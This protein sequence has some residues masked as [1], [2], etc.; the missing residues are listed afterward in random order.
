MIYGYA[1]VST[2]NQKLDSQ[3]ESLE[4]YAENNGFVFDEII[5]EKCKGKKKLSER[6]GFKKLLEKFIQED[7]LIVTELDRLGRYSEIHYDI[8]ELQKLIN[9]TIVDD[10]K[11]IDES[12]KNIL[13]QSIIAIEEGKNI[14][15][16]VKRG[17]ESAKKRGVKLGRPKNK[18]KVPREFIEKYYFYKAGE[19]GDISVKKFCKIC[20]IGR[21][22]YYKYEK[23]LGKLEKDVIEFNCKRKIRE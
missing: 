11:D 18:E 1:R 4:L 10:G 7:I 19:Y 20:D 9:I 15:K 8:L 16:R 21:S 12:I 17:L 14:R 2:S 6:K 22:T 23:S 3:I 5:S 13:V